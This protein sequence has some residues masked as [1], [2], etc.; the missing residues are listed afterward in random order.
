MFDDLIEELRDAGF[1]TLAYADDLAACGEDEEELKRAI[2]I[3]E[4]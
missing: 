1:I 2:T 4:K 3:C